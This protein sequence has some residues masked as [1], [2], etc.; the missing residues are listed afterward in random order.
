MEN[1]YASGNRIGDLLAGDDESATPFEIEVHAQRIAVR[2]RFAGEVQFRLAGCDGKPARG[3]LRN[4]Q[5]FE[6]SCDPERSQYMAY[7]V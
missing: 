2:A 1:E 7:C 4:R 3:V 6:C 5:R